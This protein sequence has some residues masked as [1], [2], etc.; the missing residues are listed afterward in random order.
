LQRP[1]A[2]FLHVL[3]D[4]LQ[5]WE[6][7]HRTEDAARPQRVADALFDAVP[8]GDGDVLLVGVETANLDHVHH[9]VGALER[10]TAM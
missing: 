8:L 6:G 3:H 7:A 2:Q 4:R 1:R 9:V 10:F 5:D